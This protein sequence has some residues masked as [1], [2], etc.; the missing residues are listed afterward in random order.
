MNA[1]QGAETESKN[2]RLLLLIDSD[3]L[4]RWYIGTHLRARIEIT[5]VETPEE[6]RAALRNKRFD[7]VIL[8]NDHRVKEIGK[9]ES[10]SS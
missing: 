7:A 3:V 9:L 6:G 2:G 4:L 5:V 8:S 1:N 10:L